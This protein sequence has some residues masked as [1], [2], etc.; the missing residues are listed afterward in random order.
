[1]EFDEA[2]NQ[3]W[4]VRGASDKELLLG[5]HLDSVP[6][7]GWLDGALNVVAG[8]EV[9]RRHRRGGRAAG[10][11]AA[12]QLGRR[13]R[14]ALRPLALRLERG[15]GVDGRPGR[16]SPADRCRG[17]LAAGRDRR[18]RRRPRP[19]GRGPDAA[20]EGRGLPRAA[21]RA[22]PGAREHGSPARGRARHLRRR[23][24]PGDVPRP[25]CP[26]RLD[27]DGPA[28]R[29]AG[30]RCAARARDLR[31]RGEG[32]R[33]LHDG[34]RRH[35]AGH[36]HVRRGDG[37]MP[38]RPAAPGSRQAR[39]DAG[40]RAGCRGPVRRQAQRRGRLGADLAD[41]ADPL[42]RA[43]DRARGRGDQG[44]RR[45]LAPPAERPAARRGRGRHVQASRP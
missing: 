6:N 40:R 37:R 29:R 43:A 16:A 30:G 7:G 25:G 9:L 5:G 33:G 2:R 18:A 44:G 20:R 15:G 35:Q 11:R 36:R 10:H 34:E 42:R 26:C 31:D 3:W 38:A 22:R 23:A 24:P 14:G 1:M 39:L 27:A 4:T 45:H 19:G 32:R 17:D 8:A 41:R 28:P 12:R 13:G 21:H